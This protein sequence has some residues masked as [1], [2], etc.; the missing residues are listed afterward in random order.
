MN[1]GDGVS[2]KK[3]FAPNFIKVERKVIS[4][5]WGRVR[6]WKC[7]DRI[8]QLFRTLGEW[9]ELYLDHH[10][11]LIFS[12]RLI[13]IERE[14]SWYGC[15]LFKSCLEYK[16]EMVLLLDLTSVWDFSRWV[17][18]ERDKDLR[19]SW[20]NMILMLDCY[21]LDRKCLPQKKAHV[22]NAWSLN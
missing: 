14:M 17:H 4:W 15:V 16:D 13:V 9:M 22:L 8:K 12:L 2:V 10:M 18:R 6:N 21:G 1:T 3:F 19:Y 7:K 5:W 11:A 20:F